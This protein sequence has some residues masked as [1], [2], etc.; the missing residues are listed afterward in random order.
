MRLIYDNNLS[1]KLVELLS[2]LF[3]ESVHVKD[4][5]LQSANDIEIWNYAKSNNL[6]IVSKDKDFYHLS[7]GIGG[8]PKFIWLILGNCTIEDTADILR[9]RID[10][11]LEFNKSDK[12]I[13]IL[14]RIPN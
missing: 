11:I 4:A 14:Q 9:K 13:L 5:N 7:S 2:D 10:E 8:P 1:V 12:D 6:T 3:P